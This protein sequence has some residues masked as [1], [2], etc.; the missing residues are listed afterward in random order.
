MIELGTAGAG[1][2]HARLCFRSKY[3]DCSLWSRAAGHR[4][5]FTY[6]SHPVSLSSSSNWNSLISGPYS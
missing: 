3:S 2:Q 1:V 4:G 6:T 5:Q